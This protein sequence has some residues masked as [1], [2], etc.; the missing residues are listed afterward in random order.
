[1]CLRILTVLLCAT[2]AGCEHSEHWVTTFGNNIEGNRRPIFAVYTFVVLI[3]AFLAPLPSLD[4]ADSYHPCSR[5]VLQ[6]SWP[7]CKLVIEPFSALILIVGPRWLRSWF[8]ASVL[9]TLLWEALFLLHLFISGRMIGIA[10]ARVVLSFPKALQ[11]LVDY[12][13]QVLALV[14]FPSNR[15]D[16]KLTHWS[17]TLVCRDYAATV[18]AEK[19]F[20][21]LGVDHRIYFSTSCSYTCLCGNCTPR[22]EPGVYRRNACDPDAW[23]IYHFHFSSHIPQTIVLKS[24]MELTVVRRSGGYT[25]AKVLPVFPFSASFSPLLQKLVPL[26]YPKVWGCFTMVTRAKTKL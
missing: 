9:A 16:C 12:F 13:G 25:V 15:H 6:L 8:Y 1:M 5:F 14:P 2:A 7:T 23:G 24:F 10:N 20:N 3:L 18:P 19:R 11:N 17:P 21:L 26:L 22:E 4:F